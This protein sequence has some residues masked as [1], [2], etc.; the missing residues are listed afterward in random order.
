MH[1]PYPFE[2]LETWK[3]AMSAG[4]AGLAR[5]LADPAFRQSVKDEIARP[6]RRLFTGEWE[7]IRVHRV[8]SGAHTT[9]EGRTLAELAAQTGRHPLDFMLDL[10]LEENLDTVYTAALQNS[11]EDAVKRLILDPSTMI[12][13]SDAG[14]HLSFLC[15]AGFALHLFGHWV[16]EKGALKL[17][18]AVRKVTS[19]PAELFGLKDRGR[20]VVGAHADLLLFDPASVG[21]TPVE[22]HNDMPAGA[23]RLLTK[24]L[25]VHGVWVNGQ[26]VANERGLIADAKPAGSVLREFR[27]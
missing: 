23:S 10:S 9:C 15:D 4:K 5:V 6:A 11:D 21:R 20:L 18:A 17:E 14:A 22:R 24:P 2:G 19:E 3:P 8:S 1:D 25:G 12:S 7:K 13:L 26:R 27:A 16:R